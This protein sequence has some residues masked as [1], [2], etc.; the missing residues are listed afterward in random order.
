MTILSSLSLYIHAPPVR[1][2]PSACFNTGRL[3][4]RLYSTG[5]ER[6]WYRVRWDQV[7]GNVVVVDPFDPASLLYL[8]QPQ[9]QDLLKT[10]LAN[11][12]P[13]VVVHGL[14]DLI[15]EEREI[16]EN[17]LT[18]R[19]FFINNEEVR[20]ARHIKNTPQSVMGP[21]ES[22]LTA[23]AI[24]LFLRRNKIRPEESRR[25]F[26]LLPSIL[27]SEVKVRARWPSEPALAVG[28][29]PL[30]GRSPKGASES[31]EDFAAR[32]AATLEATLAA[33]FAWAGCT[34]L[35]RSGRAFGWTATVLQ[36]FL[37]IW[38]HNSL[39]VA[40]ATYAEARRLVYKFVAGTP[41]VKSRA[42]LPLGVAHGLPTFLP[43][44]LRFY[45]RKGDLTAIRLTLFLLSICDLFRYDAP[46]KVSTIVDP[47]SGATPLNGEFETEVRE[48]AKAFRAKHG[49]IPMP[50]WK[51]LHLTVKAGT[52]G[53]AMASAPMD[54]WALEVSPAWEHFKALSHA[55]GAHKLVTRVEWMSWVTRRLQEVVG[56]A[57]RTFL[58]E[59]LESRMIPLGTQLR[60]APIRSF[61][62]S[63]LLGILPTG[64]IAQKV[65]PRGKIRIFAIP[66]YWVQTILRGISDALFAYLKKLPHDN[67]FAQTSGI[68]RVVA[69]KSKCIWS[70]DL[71]AATDRFPLEIQSWV[72][73]E[74]I[75]TPKPAVAKAVAT[76]WAGLLRSL[77]FAYKP[78]PKSP[79][80]YLSYGAGQPMGAYS[81]WTAFT[82]AHH[83][84]VQV[85]ARRAGVVDWGNYE[86]LGDDI[87][88]HGDQPC[89]RI[90]AETYSELMNSV[91]VGINPIKG[92]ESE[93][94]TFEFAKRLVREGDTLTSLKWRE[95][96]SIHT[97]TDVLSVLNRLLDLCGHL[98]QLR[99]ALEVGFTLVRGY[100]Y[101]RPLH[102]LDSETVRRLCRRSA[103]FGELY[104]QLAGPTGPYMSSFIGWL[105]GTSFWMTDFHPNVGRFVPGR[106]QMR[107]VNGRVAAPM[108]FAI[109]RLRQ[110]LARRVLGGTSCATRIVDSMLRVY[111]GLPAF[112]SETL[113]QTRTSL[114]YC[115]LV[116][117]S[118]LVS[119]VKAG[120]A[121]WTVHRALHDL[122]KVNTTGFKESWLRSLHPDQFLID[123]H[124]LRAQG[125]NPDDS[126]KVTI[127]DSQ[128]GI[129][130]HRIQPLK[131]VEEWTLSFFPDRHHQQY[132]A[133]LGI[134]RGALEAA[135]HLGG[136]ITQSITE[137]IP[138]ALPSW[139]DS[140]EEIRRISGR[141]VVQA[142]DT[143]MGMSNDCLAAVARS[144]EKDAPG[145]SPTP[146]VVADELRNGLKVGMECVA[147][148]GPLELGSMGHARHPE[149]EILDVTPIPPSHDGSE[150]FLKTGVSDFLNWSS[151]GDYRV[152]V[153]KLHERHRVPSWFRVPVTPEEY[154][155]VTWYV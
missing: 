49:A 120:P 84:M 69:A 38:Q 77:T 90:I 101:P 145:D 11:R 72:L 78:K 87:I 57:I 48:T 15:P 8:P 85:A 100:P 5:A 109:D 89:D 66:G 27:R 104:I 31:D 59:G 58:R 52:F 53:T 137:L 127:S 124:D 136:F 42:P 39:P 143:F 128:D 25:W 83:V 111:P 115:I 119:V 61:D 149:V 71:S 113:Q 17:T 63:R 91:G 110:E 138:T 130:V 28:R 123:L 67:T 24:S 97:W 153:T 112:V 37:H 81:S 46:A 47:Y 79:T 95:L 51:G 150:E 96:S 56:V 62:I 45:L 2:A 133:G 148:H 32:Q 152:G 102:Q 116:S 125:A 80:V 118:P 40:S 1:L 76:A 82:L 129:Q 43:R 35:V 140:Q 4:I 117:A 122:L 132:A 99:T 18:F 139:V 70:Y 142:Y 107:V 141:A 135:G 108:T 6:L 13:L 151:A 155:C 41:D 64:K 54:A 103:I 60:G 68:S 26:E 134:A 21:T 14:N 44:G 22:L 144:K 30:D 9:Y 92:L 75:D 10:A 20:S 33:R 154:G 34:L 106:R 36:H 105:S 23:T 65:E 50:R 7:I 146:R 12:T 98:P 121:Y 16:T 19:A 114:M 74:L 131:E 86:I 94:G 29:R 126:P 88:L 3:S 55:L 93:N 147:P 73:E